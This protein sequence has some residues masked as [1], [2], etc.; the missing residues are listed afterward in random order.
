MFYFPHN[1]INF[2]VVVIGPVLIAA[3]VVWFPS[4][5]ANLNIMFY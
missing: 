2:D 4:G 3:A 5:L 1:A